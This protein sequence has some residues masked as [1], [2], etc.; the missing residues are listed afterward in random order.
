MKGAIVAKVVIAL[1]VFPVL[2]HAI[3][4]ALTMLLGPMLPTLLAM[5]ENWSELLRK[6]LIGAAF[7]IA[8]RSSFGVCRRLWP[9][10]R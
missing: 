2:V 6:C 4:T 5:A 9:V 7:L 3:F 8:V 10:T 1:L